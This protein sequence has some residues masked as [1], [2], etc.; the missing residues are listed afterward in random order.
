[1]MGFSP[2]FLSMMGEYG[3][4]GNVRELFGALEYAMT[5]AL[6]EQTLFPYHLPT[7]IRAQVVRSSFEGAASPPSGDEISVHPSTGKGATDRNQFPKWK[8]FRKAL[9]NDGEK[10]YLQ[11]LLALAE[12]DVKS[13]SRLS[14]LSVPRIYELLRKHG[15]STR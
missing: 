15:L 9:V 10:Q 6:E 11:N 1:M 4:P 7:H 2:D 12:G 5:Q 13:A 8:E 3:W 14:D